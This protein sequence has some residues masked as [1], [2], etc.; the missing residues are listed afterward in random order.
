MEDWGKKVKL[1]TDLKLRS[2][3]KSE[4]T[5]IPNIKL[6]MIYAP[7]NPYVLPMACQ[8]VYNIATKQVLLHQKY[9]DS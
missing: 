6:L 2:R 7:I 3:S 8:R 1:F 9:L 5:L 4:F